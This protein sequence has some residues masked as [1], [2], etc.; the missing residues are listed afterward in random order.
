MTR[1][2]GALDLTKRDY[3]TSVKPTFVTGTGLQI[4]TG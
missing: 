2:S 4:M 3:V 1:L